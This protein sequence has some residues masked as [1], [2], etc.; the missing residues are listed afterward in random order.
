MSFELDSKTIKWLYQL[1]VIGQGDLKQ[2]SNSLFE[3]KEPI[4]N[5][6]EN[7]VK[8]SQIVIEIYKRKGLPIPS[9][10]NHLKL[11]NNTAAQLYNWN[12]LNE[13]NFYS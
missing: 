3:V 7:G 2:Q 12:I 10:M 6:F 9:T 5:Q 4:A 1:R 8:I 13:V 11:S